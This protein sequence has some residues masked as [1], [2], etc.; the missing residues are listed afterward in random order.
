MAHIDELELPFGTAGRPAKRGRL[1]DIDGV[2]EELNTSVRH[3]RRLVHE[4]RIPVV[5][6]GRLIRFDPADIEA[7][8]DE[9]RTSAEP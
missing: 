7:W 8:L 4:R 6:M 5:R 3:I 9:H 1:L 2:A